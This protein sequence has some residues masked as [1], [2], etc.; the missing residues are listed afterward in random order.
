MSKREELRQRRQ[1]QAQ[2]Q[3]L[4]IIGGVSL[5]AIAIAAFFIYQSVTENSRPI[6]TIVPV[7]PQN[8]TLTNGQPMA[9][10]KILGSPEA[11]V[12]IEVYS[13]FQCPFCGR[14]AR[15]VEEEVIA[16]YVATGQARLIYKHFIVVDD[17]VGGQESHRAALAS[18]CASEQGQFWNYHNLVF[19]NQSGEGQGAFAD[20]RLKAFAETLS[21]NT[22]QF[23][24]CFDS[25]KYA[26]AL[27]T[28]QNDGVAKGV[29]GTPSVFINNIQ[30]QNP[31]D[32]A[33]YQRIIAAQLG[34]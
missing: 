17:N 12:A 32:L 6:G 20:R 25:S 15:E 13:D 28:D 33:E 18:E 19:A 9:N 22:E 2:R 16:T 11:P 1:A 10:G 8:Y 24:S 29:R 3:R 4:F 14:L 34:Q 30:M 5:V 31:L 21:L 27:T 7:T 26:S 23:N